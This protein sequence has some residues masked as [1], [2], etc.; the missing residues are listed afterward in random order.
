MDRDCIKENLFEEIEEICWG[1]IERNEEQT[2]KE[3]LGFDSL[4]E[5]YLLIKVERLFGIEIKDEEAESIK[6]VKEA[7]DLIEKKLQ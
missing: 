3:D 4:D 1:D 2:F 7:I 6:T 5:E